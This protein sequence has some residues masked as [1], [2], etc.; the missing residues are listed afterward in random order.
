MTTLL[1]YIDPGS[2]TLLFQMVA[3]AFVGLFFYIKKIRTWFLDLFRSP[4][5]KK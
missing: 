1:A 3:A 4:G 5:Q 2:G